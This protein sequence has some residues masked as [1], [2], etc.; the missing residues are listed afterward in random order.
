MK[1]MLI[2]LSFWTLAFSS[3]SVKPEHIPEVLT[4]AILLNECLKEGEYCNP[5]IIS[6]NRKKDIKKAKQ[7]GFEFYKRR[8]IYCYNTKECIET[9]KK[10]NKIGINNLDLGPFQINMMYNKMEDYGNYFEFSKSKKEVKKI[11][12]SL[13]NKFGYSWYTIGRYHSG[14]NKLNKVYC[15]SLWKNI[16]KIQKEIK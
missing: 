10:L 15:N 11:L 2:L 12:A 7:N 8:N 9:V 16:K 4:T 1:L 13:I 6:F 5:Y 3:N 14:T